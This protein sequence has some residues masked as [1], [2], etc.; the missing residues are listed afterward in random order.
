MAQSPDFVETTRGGDEM[1]VKPKIAAAFVA[2]ALASG[3][4]A[5]VATAAASHADDAPSV[6]QAPAGSH[7]A[8]TDN[9]D[10][11]SVPGTDELQAPPP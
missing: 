1:T 5:T 9:V 7:D 4:G 6:Q 8:Y 10:Q 3:V 11:A 2:L